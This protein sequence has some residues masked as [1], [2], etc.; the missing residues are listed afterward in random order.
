MRFVMTDKEETATKTKLSLA[1]PGK[2]ELKKLLRGGKF[3][4]AFL[5]A[6]QR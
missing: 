3:V 4:K 1:R 2:L 6:D 5:T